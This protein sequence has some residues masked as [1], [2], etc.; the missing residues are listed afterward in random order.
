[1]LNKF[2]LLIAFCLVVI[3][4]GLN[5]EV[6][7]AGKNVVMETT[8][9]TITI[10]LYDQKAPI[11]VA[12]FRKYVQDGF[13]DG[14]LFHRVMPNFVIQGGGFEPGM[15]QKKTRPNIKN[16]ANNGLKNK[17]GTLSM[18]RQNQKDTASSQFFVNLKDNRML[19]HKGMYQYGYAVFGKVIKGMDVV[20]KIA[21]SPTGTVSFYRDVPIRDVII[22]RAYEK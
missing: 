6:F 14:L 2:R 10:Q 4:C 3:F 21:K 16:E 18:A 8:H 1:M 15:K 7:A 5:T 19:D 11:T 22:K 9:G 13:F 12:N 20:D 17:R